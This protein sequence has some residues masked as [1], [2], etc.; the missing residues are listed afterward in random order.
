MFGNGYFYNSIKKKYAS[1]FN[2][3]VKI[4]TKQLYD[5]LFYSFYYH[6]FDKTYLE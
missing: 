2:S 6:V 1:H 5:N 3:P 4:F